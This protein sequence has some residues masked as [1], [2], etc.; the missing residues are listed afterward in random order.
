MVVSVIRR[1]S[2]RRALWHLPV[3]AGVVGLLALIGARPAAALDHQPAGNPSIKSMPSP[4]RSATAS[5]TSR[6]VHCVGRVWTTIGNDSRFG[7]ESEGQVP[8]PEDL[9]KLGI[10][11][12]PSFEFPSASRQE[13]LFEGSIWIG[14][15]VGADTLVSEGHEGWAGAGGEFLGFTKYMEGIPPGYPRDCKPKD[16]VTRGLQQV[17][18]CVY[19]DT[20]IAPGTS[21][22]D[23]P[24]AHL[25]IGLEITQVSHQGSDLYSSGFVIVD[26]WIRNIT[27]HPINDVWLGVFSD[28]DIFYKPGS[29]GA[30]DDISG[31]LKYWPNP[32][33][34][35]Y[36]DTLDVAWAADNDGD[37][38]ASIR[39]FGRTSVPGAMG[40]R[41]LRAPA[42]THINFNWWTAD[43]DP[44]HD[45]GPRKL[46]DLR[47]FGTGGNGTPPSDRA[48]YA[49]MSN[50]EQD[51]GQLFTP[52]DSSSHGWRPPPP[53]P[54]SCDLG[55]GRDT[56]MLMSVGPLPRID[57]GESVPFTYAMIMGDSLHRKEEWNKVYDCR[58]PGAYY[59]K[60]H[61]SD[62]A[63][64]AWWAGF[65]FDNFG[66]DTDSNG[67]SGASFVDSVSHK[68]VY[69]TGDG[70]PD[71]SGPSSPPCPAIELST[72]PYEITVHWTG[73]K[74]ETFT[75][76][77]L[78]RK[79]F[80][81]YRVYVSARNAKS[82]IP[83]AGDYSLLASWDRIDFRRYTYESRDSSWAVT[84]DPLDS[85]AWADTLHDP[86]FNP[87]RYPH[88]SLDNCYHYTEQDS[89]GM[90]VDVCA[91]FAPQDYNMGNDYL[92]GGEMIH[93]VI[94][95]DSTGRDAKNQKYGFYSVTL[96]NLLPSKVYFVTVTSFDQ[97]D[98]LTGTP[99]LEST[100]GQC[101]ASGI[102][103]YSAGFVEA[104][105]DSGGAKR[106]SVKVSVYPNPYKFSYV[107]PD[108][109]RTSYFEEGYEG[110]VGQTKLDERD[111]RIHF[112]NVPS[113]ATID[114]YTLDGD[115]VRTLTHPDKI[116]SGYS[117]EISWDLISRNTQAVASGVYIYR[118][119]SKLGSQLGK[120][121]IIK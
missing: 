46:T 83:S 55:G 113:D 49:V 88:P 103:I 13:Y 33:A 34:P 98:P 30:S 37:P 24:R 5:F 94:Q 26:Q 76:P 86:T 82:D 107:G 115:L 28:N 80:E 84:S 120:I 63:R 47:G 92:Q 39:G 58:D 85:A 110:V 54:F 14:A 61:F 23:P 56:R 1:A 38:E 69:Y 27:D 90:P 53:Q 119:H 101:Y 9:A 74:T 17:F 25:P 106:D 42:G 112:I 2:L 91:Y 108:G 99:S 65:V 111:R 78:L 87:A 35:T 52:D 11:Y 7:T 3:V 81:G 21:D 109:R 97:G 15:I 114:I 4:V 71:F 20:M 105:W 70:C 18:N 50:G 95:Q 79:D 19:Y 67:W 60:L 22:P 45:W 31:F 118:V 40:F 6:R 64:N 68:R 43:Q 44:N 93:N 41:I 75:D 12:G 121:V 51:Y 73:E 116:L 72:R 96:K 32:S 8:D 57:P 89:L 36:M 62:L 59:A 117:S 77:Q 104:Y 102:P 100:P 10:T 29:G 66:V 48:K 16:T